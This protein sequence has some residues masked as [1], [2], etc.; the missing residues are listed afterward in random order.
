M[1][2]RSTFLYGWGYLILLLLFLVKIKSLAVLYLPCSFCVELFAN[3]SNLCRGMLKSSSEGRQ[4]ASLPCLFLQLQWHCVMALSP[5]IFVPFYLT[6][7][8]FVGSGCLMLNQDQI[9]KALFWS[10]SITLQA[11]ND[12]RSMDGKCF[13]RA[14]LFDSGPPLCLWAKFTLLD[15]FPRS[16]LGTKPWQ[17]SLL[18]VVHWIMLQVTNVVTKTQTYKTLMLRTGH[19]R[20]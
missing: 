5:T 16:S 11:W 14:W 6:V 4:N 10:R 8:C 15:R 20:W 18:V 9:T 2:E 7:C 1:F 17:T 13:H 12:K 19:N 3:W